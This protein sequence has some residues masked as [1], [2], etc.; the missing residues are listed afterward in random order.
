MVPETSAKEINQ[1]LA[2]NP[3]IGVVIG[4]RYRLRRRL[5]IPG[6]HTVS[7]S[8]IAGTKFSDIGRQ[9]N[10]YQNFPRILCKI[11][12]LKYQNLNFTQIDFR[13]EIELYTDGFSASSRNP[14]L[15]FAGQFYA[16]VVTRLYRRI[17]I[18]PF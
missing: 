4:H 15:H 2:E 13:E 7:T 10:Q 1:A 6:T 8:T 17:T 14:A 5:G 16:D 11:K 3:A 12:T 18:G 9:W